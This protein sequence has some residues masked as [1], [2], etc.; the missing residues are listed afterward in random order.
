MPQIDL[1]SKIY[2][3]KEIPWNETIYID[4]IILDQNLLKIHKERID[5][6]FSNASQEI[7]DQQLQNIL[8]RDTLFNKAM[9]IV[10]QCYSFEIHPDDV[11]FFIPPLKAN[12]PEIPNLN[13]EQYEA[14]IKEIAEK[15]VQKQLI[16][17]DIANQD[18]IDVSTEEMLKVLDEYHNSTGLPIDEIKNDKEKLTGAVSALLEEKITAHIINK[19]PK[20]LDALYQ[21]M[22]KDLNEMAKTLDEH[23]K[24]NNNQ[25]Q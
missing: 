7:R 6:V 24:N 14:R 9:D 19:F 17:N 2:K 1:K 3:V 15:L 13:N 23:N 20:N 5:K 16:F 8:L 25:Q 12:V 4:K 21:N 10:A 11:N 22:Q 18:K